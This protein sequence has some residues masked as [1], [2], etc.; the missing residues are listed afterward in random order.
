M[1]PNQPAANQPAA[2]Q[3]AAN[4]PAA[5]QP[6]ANQHAAGQPAQHAADPANGSCIISRT[7]TQH[8][9]IE[10][11]SGEK[12]YIQWNMGEAARKLHGTRARR[13]IAG[14]RRD[15]MVSTGLPGLWPARRNER[16]AEEQAVIFT[17]SDDVCVPPAGQP[18]HLPEGFTAIDVR[19][20]DNSPILVETEGRITYWQ[21]YNE[22]TNKGGFGRIKALG[23]D[24]S[25][26]IVSVDADNIVGD[27]GFT[28]EPHQNP[29]VPQKVW[30]TA[31]RHHVHNRIYAEQVHAHNGGGVMLANTP[32]GKG[33]EMEF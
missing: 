31:R 24:G 30:F 33:S 18:I 17:L 13:R 27:D 6:A 11:A 25:R 15:I 5:N 29:K 10:G 26:M 16:Y 28:L 3:P 20:P 4:Q 9:Y 32:E 8:G 14:D 22:S 21:K 23:R 12:V 2:S 1:Q 7:E 19:R